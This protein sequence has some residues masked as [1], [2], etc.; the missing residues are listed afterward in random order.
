[1]LA[2]DTNLIVR[3][4]T[5]DRPRQVGAG[6]NADRRRR[7]ARLLDALMETER[8]SRLTNRLGAVKVRAP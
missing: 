4:L 8:V 2:I 3:Y 7:R 1:M 6:E 5:G